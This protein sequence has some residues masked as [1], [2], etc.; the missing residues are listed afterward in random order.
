MD[1]TARS[2]ALDFDNPVEL[3]RRLIRFDTSNP[4][5]NEADC[6]L[7]IDRLLTDAELEVIRYEPYPEEPDTGLFPHFGANALSELLKRYKAL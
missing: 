2:A 1:T 7:Y 3:A 6:I 4:P 5:G